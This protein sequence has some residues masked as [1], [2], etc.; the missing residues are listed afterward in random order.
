[1]GEREIKNSCNCNL[2]YLLDL[3]KNSGESLLTA[4]RFDL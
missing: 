4:K 1:M 3:E 2:F